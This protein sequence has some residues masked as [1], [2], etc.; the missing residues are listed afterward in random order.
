MIKRMEGPARAIGKGRLK[1]A[2]HAVSTDT[3]A[4]MA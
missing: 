3:A 4:A 2:M 1:L